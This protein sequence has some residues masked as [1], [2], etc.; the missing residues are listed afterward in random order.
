MNPRTGG[1]NF[2]RFCVRLWH[3]Q[4][5]SNS[6]LRLSG[7]NLTENRLAQKNHNLSLHSVLRTLRPGCRFRANLHPTRD[8]RKL[9]DLQHL[10][11]RTGDDAR[12]F[13]LP[14]SG[15]REAVYPR[16]NA[17]GI[18]QGNRR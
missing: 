17:T 6:G 2:L 14:T 1:K 11:S 18:R 15:Q 3:S 7:R 16:R 4:I 13:E 9:T 10:F 8:N 12:R 5:H